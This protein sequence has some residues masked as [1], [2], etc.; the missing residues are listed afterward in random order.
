MARQ[1]FPEERREIE[2]SMNII[3]Y[4]KCIK[5]WHNEHKVYP[6]VCPLDLPPKVQN[7]FNSD[8][9]ICF[10]TVYTRQ[11]DLFIYSFIHQFLY[12]P[13]L[14]PGLFFSSVIFFIQSV[15]LLGR[16]ISLS[17]GRY[18]HKGQH[19]QRINAH[20]DIYAL[21]GIQTHDPSVRRQFMP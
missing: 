10:R 4:T 13:L 9:V 12:S 20:T 15:G 19:K 16:V 17:Q 1:Y 5:L 14:G 21:S 18:L 11:P 2:G 8:C 6:A 3:F 7:E